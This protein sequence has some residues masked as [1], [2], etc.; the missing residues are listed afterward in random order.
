MMHFLSVYVVDVSMCL[1][2]LSYCVLRDTAV[3]LVLLRRLPGIFLLD[4]THTALDCSV[5]RVCGGGVV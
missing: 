4:D 1:S 2:I 3:A 5:A